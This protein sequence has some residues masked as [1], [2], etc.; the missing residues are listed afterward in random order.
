MPLITTHN[1][2][3]NTVFL[4][5][6]K[7]VTRTFEEKKNFYELFAQGFDPFI[8]YEFFK[9]KK[10]DLQ[11]YCHYNKTDTFFLNFI[12]LIK[13]KHLEK[14]PSV[15]ASLYGHLTHYVLDSTA[16][17]YIV[18]KCGQYFKEKP[19]TLK[20]NGRHNKMEMEIDAYLYE[21]KYHKPYRNFAIHKHL[22]TKEKWDKELIPLLNEVYEMTYPIKNGGNKYKK[23][24]KNMYYSYKFLITDKTGIKKKVYKLVDRLTKNKKGVYEN[25][26]TYVSSVD[27]SI[28]NN[29]HLVWLNPWNKTESIESFFDLFEKAKK[30]CIELFIETH[31]YLHN[32]ITEEEYKKTLKDNSYVTGFSWHTKA[33]MKYLEF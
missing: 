26:S 25:Y 20:Y 32:E 6:P 18:Y 19:E 28:F 9:L 14:N 16:H 30:H 11:E 8:F 23:G 4:D 2:F 5:T 3:A 22:I 15:L 13:E 7:E 21:Q 1:F 27:S 12:R 24:C 17:P 31:K 10:Q 33:E 29:E